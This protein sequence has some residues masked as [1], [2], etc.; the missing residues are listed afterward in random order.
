VT[1]LKLRAGGRRSPSTFPS[2]A[3]ETMRAA[4]VVALV[5]V[6]CLVLQ[7]CAGDSA[8]RARAVPT[9]RAEVDFSA[10]PTDEKAL[11]DLNFQ[12]RRM[13]RRAQNRCTNQAANI[14][15]SACVMGNV[16]G[17]VAQANDPALTAFHWAL[18]RQ[19]RYDPER[20]SFIWKNVRNYV[21]RG[22]AE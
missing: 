11:T 5:G 17:S 14:A 18:P 7:A 4:I 16:D 22:A 6:G 1:I 15:S 2:H 21:P 19:H 12:Q 8:E 9:S 10:L 3:E 20:P 13:V